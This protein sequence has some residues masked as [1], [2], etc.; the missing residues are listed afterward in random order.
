MI[1]SINYIEHGYAIFSAK[2]GSW[3]EGKEGLGSRFFQNI[4]YD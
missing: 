4:Y 3:F 2:Y 1:F